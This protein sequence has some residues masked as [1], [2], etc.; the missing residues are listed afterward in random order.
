MHLH[1]SFNIKLI[2][3]LP[4]FVVTM[5]AKPAVVYAQT[6]APDSSNKS[7]D[8][9]GSFNDAEIHLS[10]VKKQ[11][12]FLGGKKAWHDFLRSNINIKI[13]FSNKAPAGVYKVMIRFIVGSDGKL[14]GIG[15]DSNCGYGMEAGVIRCINKSNNWMP[16]ETNSG[17]KVSFTL[18][19]G[20]TF[21]VKQNEVLIQFP[22]DNSK[23]L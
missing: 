7:I 12:E 15:A 11:P 23:T 10:A 4:L 5:V 16:A 9:F 14:R 20:V 8:V 19:T 21:V 17:K 6:Y 2:S 1:H 22:E 13:S 18:R 3:I